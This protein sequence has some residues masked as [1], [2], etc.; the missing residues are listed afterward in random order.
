M[1]PTEFEGYPVSSVECAVIRLVA[2]EVEEQ[3]RESLAIRGVTPREFPAF[4]RLL[5]AS[6]MLVSVQSL[7]ERPFRPSATH[8]TP[9]NPAGRFS[10]GEHP[11]YY[12]ALERETAISE[13]IHM[14]K[15]QLDTL[16][17]SSFPF[18]FYRVFAA[19][20]RGDTANLTTKPEEHARLTSDTHDYCK[21]LRTAAADANL[22]GFH[23]PS[24]RRTGGICTPTFRR[25]ALLSIESS[26]VVKFEIRDTIAVEE[27]PD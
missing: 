20:Y 14:L 18:A 6:D 3:L 2:F 11:V 24:A 8:P 9:Y 27:L 1:P 22:H 10:T 16:L 23:T 4:V 19:A 21:Q 13:M 5:E 15:P 25:D 17:A 26:G 12:A 7:L